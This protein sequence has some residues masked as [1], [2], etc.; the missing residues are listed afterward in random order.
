MSFTCIRCGKSFERRSHLTEHLSKKKPCT[1]TCLDIPIEEVC[2][3]LNI[4]LKRFGCPHC[5]L[6]LT[7]KQ[8]YKSHVDN[9][10]CRKEQR[11]PKVQT[12]EGTHAPLAINATINNNIQINISPNAFTAEGKVNFGSETWDHITKEMIRSYT[13]VQPIL[14]FSR[15]V[16]DLYHHRSAPQN[17]TVT[18][19]DSDSRFMKIVDNG[20]VT[21]MPRSDVLGV[22][23]IKTNSCVTELMKME[24]HYYDYIL[25]EDPLYDMLK[26]QQDDAMRLQQWVN[27][28]LL[29]ER[30][31][32]KRTS[33]LIEAQ[34]G[35]IVK[36]RAVTGMPTTF[37]D[38]RMPNEIVPPDYNLDDPWPRALLNDPPKAPFSEGSIGSGD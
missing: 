29:P 28:F 27:Q 17:H 9:F 12:C 23:R 38:C 5:N 2:E 24:M 4:Q 37:R 13:S 32:A 26:Q 36:L 3:R 10:V 31:D 11:P 16:D 20:A 15:L 14:G 35:E 8:R 6:V 7:T 22:M 18:I 33:K 21:I 34:I 19:C 30:R 25:P 1:P